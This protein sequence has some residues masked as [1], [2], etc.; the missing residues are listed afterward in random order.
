MTAIAN[1]STPSGKLSS[2]VEKVRFSPA[3]HAI[4]HPAGGDMGKAEQ[5]RRWEGLTGAEGGA[6]LHSVTQYAHLPVPVPKQRRDCAQPLPV[7]YRPSVP[8]P[9]GAHGQ[10]LRRPDAVLLQKRP[11]QGAGQGA[12]PVFR[13]GRAQQHLPLPA[14]HPHLPHTVP[15][16]QAAEKAQMQRPLRLIIALALRQA[17]QL[18]SHQSK[19][20]PVIPA[21]D[22]GRFVYT[23]L[24]SAHPASAE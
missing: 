24:I 20:P 23:Y 1:L 5:R 7:G 3:V 22:R 17:G 11:G 2:V 13:R 9:H 15:R 8:L 16:R 6:Q 21:Y 12:R 4:V 10:A 18:H 19:T 14:P